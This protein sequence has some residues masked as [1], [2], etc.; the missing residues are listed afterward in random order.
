MSWQAEV[1]VDG[2]ASGEVLCLDSP[3]SFW[4]GV[5]ATTSEVILPGHPQCGERVAGRILVV[6]ML[7]GSSSSSAIILELLYKGLAPC[8]VILGVQD[9][10]LPVGVL[11]SRQMSWTVIP[12]LH[13]QDPPF[14]TGDRLNIQ[15]G[16]AIEA[17]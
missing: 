11:V 17:S 15:V 2:R 13:M 16:G 8:A 7:I 3:L 4:G 5:S 6:P 12:V 9:A 14:R 1:L 10:I